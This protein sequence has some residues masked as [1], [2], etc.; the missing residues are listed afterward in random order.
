[1]KRKEWRKWEEKSGNFLS[2][3][4]DNCKGQKYIRLSLFLLLLLYSQGLQ[5]HPYWRLSLNRHI[6]PTILSIRKQDISCWIFTEVVSRSLLHPVGLT[7]H[8]PSGM[9]SQPKFPN[10]ILLPADLPS[11]EGFGIWLR[12]ISLFREMLE[13]CIRRPLVYTMCISKG[14][15][16]SA[17]GT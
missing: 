16:L 13:R 5:F 10:S 7:I 3:G 2:E 6:L 11:L 4:E 1:M 8:L 9:V 12:E 14:C 15:P 17:A